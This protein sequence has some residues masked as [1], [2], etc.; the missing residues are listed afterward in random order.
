MTVSDV[1]LAVR[2]ADGRRVVEHKL[3]TREVQIMGWSW[4]PLD[5]AP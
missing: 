4:T 3:T 1:R 2:S 5:G